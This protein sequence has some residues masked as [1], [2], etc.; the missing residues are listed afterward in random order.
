MTAPEATAKKASALRRAGPLAIAGV[1]SNGANLIVT[2]LIARLLTTREYGALAQLI[3]L[4]LVLAIPGS[5]L[6]VAVVRR[7]AAWD[8][9]GQG[10][11]VRPWA[12]RVRHAGHLGLLVFA[13]AAV[14]ISPW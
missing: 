2:V 11:R 6:V 8:H 1:A 13:I 14:A 3:G 4:F 9:S 10:Y 7:V 5:A 12:G